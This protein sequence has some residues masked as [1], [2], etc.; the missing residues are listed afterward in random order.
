MQCE[1]IPGCTPH[2]SKLSWLARYYAILR[3]LAIISQLFS[4]LCAFMR[5]VDI[6]CI[7]SLRVSANSWETIELETST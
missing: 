7:C 2:V 4:T 6:Q 5:F 3:V 1:T